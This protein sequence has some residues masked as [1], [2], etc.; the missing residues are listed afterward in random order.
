MSIYGLTREFLVKYPDWKVMVKPACISDS[1]YT[2]Y[3]YEVYAYVLG[4]KSSIPNGSVE[5]DEVTKTFTLY[6]NGFVRFAR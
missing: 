4:K 6:R 2:H 1:R 3:V 5:T